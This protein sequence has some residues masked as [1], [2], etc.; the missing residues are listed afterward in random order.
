M[1]IEDFFT[2]EGTLAPSL[3]HLTF[4]GCK[5]PKISVA[6]RWSPKLLATLASLHL[7][8]CRFPIPEEPIF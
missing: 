1:S 2:V 6:K 8:D 3:M 4:V 7:D 5:L